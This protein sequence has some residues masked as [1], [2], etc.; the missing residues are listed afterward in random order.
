MPQLR[1]TFDGV[2]IPAKRQNRCFGRKVPA[3]PEVMLIL[4]F[5]K[6]AKL[7]FLDNWQDS[8]GFR[9]QTT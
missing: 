2:Q 1:P 8:R 9:P 5:K 6:M 3:D 4:N 7:L